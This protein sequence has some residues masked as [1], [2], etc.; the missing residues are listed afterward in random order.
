MAAQ[1]PNANEEI[2]A[3]FRAGVDSYWDSQLAQRLTDREIQVGQQ[4]AQRTQ[5]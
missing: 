3:R 4:L 5:P 1:I 2:R